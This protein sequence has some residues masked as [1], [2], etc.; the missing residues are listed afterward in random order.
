M[1]GLFICNIVSGRNPNNLYSFTY[2]LCFPLFSDIIHRHY[3][4]YFSFLICNIPCHN[5]SKF[6]SMIIHF[7]YCIFFKLKH[8]CP[9]TESRHYA[10]KSGINIGE[11]VSVSINIISPYKHI[12]RQV[13]ISHYRSIQP[14]EI[15]C[16]IRQKIGTDISTKDSYLVFYVCIFICLRINIK[17]RETVFHSVTTMRKH[18]LLYIPKLFITIQIYSFR[19]DHQRNFLLKGQLFQSSEHSIFVQSILITA[20]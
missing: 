18:L 8:V 4:N 17:Q 15:G 12:A 1:E 7:L 14:R 20:N 11:F 3:T 10:G 13:P 5:I 9:F 2:H 6:K 19:Y 16:A